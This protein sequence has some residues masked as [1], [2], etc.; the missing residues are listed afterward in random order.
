MFHDHVL[1]SVWINV[2]AILAVAGT[3]ARSTC[4][5]S[6]IRREP[7]DA[8]AEGSLLD[9][10]LP[11]QASKSD[12]DGDVVHIDDLG[13]EVRLSID[14]RVPWRVALEIIRLPEVER[15]GRRKAARRSKRVAR[16]VRGPNFPLA[17]RR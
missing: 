4:R 7:Q 6:S 11:T 15:I 14:Q 12:S 5:L 9:P 10:D 3:M 2:V 13:N 16:P 1:G 17:V 8:I